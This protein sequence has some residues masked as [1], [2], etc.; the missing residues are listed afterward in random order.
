MEDFR[1][2]P[3]GLRLNYCRF[4]KQIECEH[5]GL[6]SDPFTERIKTQVD[7]LLLNPNRADPNDPEVEHLRA[8][9]WET[10]RERTV[11]RAQVWTD[12][13]TAT[14]TDAAKAL[15]AMKGKTVEE[16]P[17]PDPVPEV[18]VDSEPLGP[19][20]F[21]GEDYPSDG[22]MPLTDEEMER[23]HGPEDPTDFEEPEPEKIS[24]PPPVSEKPPL[25]PSTTDSTGNTAFPSEG[26]MLGNRERPKPVEP[27]PQAPSREDSWSPARKAKIVKPHHVH[28]FGEN[29]D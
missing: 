5:V 16:T 17:A 23:I 6:A 2:E 8:K 10:P 15:A 26:V 19:D 25:P 13:Q 12:V 11:H 3:E 4:C 27:T 1:Q 18:L 28:R 29:S 20:S 24:A 14:V 21:G 22:P 9:D 7:R